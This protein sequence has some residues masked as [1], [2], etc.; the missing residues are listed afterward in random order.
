MELV[1]SRHFLWLF[2]CLIILSI[3]SGFPVSG[4]T[5]YYLSEDRWIETVDERLIERPAFEYVTRDPS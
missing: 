4:Q 1:I 3:S 5:S 2:T